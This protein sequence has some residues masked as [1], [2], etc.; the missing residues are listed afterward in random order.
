MDK[1]AVYRDFYKRVSGYVGARLNNRSETEDVVSEVFVKVYAGLDSYDESRASLSTWIY[2]IT[3]NTLIN[4]YA[5]QSHR[6][7]A[8]ED[9]ADGLIA[10]DM[11]PMLEALAEALDE[12]DGIG[13]DIVILH[14]YH[15]LSH[16]EIA[17]KVGL[18]Y[19]NTR[20]LCSLAVSQLRRRIT[21]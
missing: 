13:R 10:K 16:Q 6:P 14:Y 2:T 18:S 12:L 8:L 21:E 20:K 5:K 9:Y 3:K 1:E 17:Q 11:D 7:L 19:A 4:H 15:G